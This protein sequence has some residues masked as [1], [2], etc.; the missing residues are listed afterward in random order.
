MAL[1]LAPLLG[2]QQAPPSQFFKWGLGNPNS[3]PYP[4]M[5]GVHKHLLS[6]VPSPFLLLFETRSCCITLVSR[7]L[8]ILS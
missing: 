4:C 6:H 7:E 8:T 5:D 3:G 2:L 1:D